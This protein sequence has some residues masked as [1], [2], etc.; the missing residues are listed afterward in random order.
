MAIAKRVIDRLSEKG[1]LSGHLE[2]YFFEKGR[3]KTTSIVS[4]GLRHLVAIDGENSLYSVWTR[5]E[6]RLLKERKDLELL[7]EYITYCSKHFSLFVAAF[8]RHI[9]EAM[10]TPDKKVSRAL[11]TTSING[12]IFCLR[13]V[14]Q[15]GKTGDADHYAQAF[16]KCTVDFSPDGFTYHSSH[17]RDLG[18]ELHK[19]CFA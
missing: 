7:E 9:D 10:W 17:W 8:Q 5:T 6:K 19:Q 16:G 14:I 2:Q 12:L 3:V 13:L 15:D 1:P 4:Y 11:T 18:R